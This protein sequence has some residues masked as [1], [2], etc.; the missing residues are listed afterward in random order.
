[1][2]TKITSF[3]LIILLKVVFIMLLW[4]WLMPKFFGITEVSFL[5]AFGFLALC[6]FLFKKSDYSFLK[7]ET[8]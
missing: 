8:T 7:N 1:M 5:E 3:L 6:G 2:A 4:N